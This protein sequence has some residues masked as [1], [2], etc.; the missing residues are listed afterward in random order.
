MDAAKRSDVTP[1]SP[2][3]FWE[4]VWEETYRRYKGEEPEHAG[5]STQHAAGRKLSKEK[6]R[7]RSR[8][9]KL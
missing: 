4:K 2:D 5:R 7:E 8:I 3:L 9:E 6:R 1:V